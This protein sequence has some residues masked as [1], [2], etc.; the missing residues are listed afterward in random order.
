MRE[1]MRFLY[2]Q[3][4][5][6][7]DPPAE[8]H[9][10]GETKHFFEQALAKASLYLE[11]GSGGSTLLADK[12]NRPTISIEGDRFYAHAVRSALRPGSPV[13]I[14]SPE[15]GLTGE[16]STPLFGAAKKASRYVQAPYALLNGRLPDLVLIDGRYRIACALEFARR[17][18]VSSERAV[19]VFDDYFDR[20]PYQEIERTLGSPKRVGRSAIF[21]VGNQH[22]D[23]ALVDSFSRMTL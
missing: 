7:F 16:W 20:P 1:L 2:V 4:V 14:I 13:P 9:F 21:E 3:R 10:D 6:G 11:Y 8:P 5:R 19:M 18:N 17:A 23:R 15:M 12:L 22:I